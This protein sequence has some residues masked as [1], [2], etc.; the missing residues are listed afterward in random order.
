MSERDQSALSE[1]GS[2]SAYRR[3]SK[4]TDPA[5]RT[6]QT[7]TMREAYLQQVAKKVD[8]EG[9]LSEIEREEAV[10]RFLQAQRAEAGR[11][12]GVARR[13]RRLAAMRERNARLVDELHELDEGAA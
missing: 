10:H 5:E 11:K 7:R 13:E 8:P 3:W 12:S 2:G 9:Q 6:E 4:V 1:W